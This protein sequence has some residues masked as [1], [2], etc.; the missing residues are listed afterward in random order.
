MQDLLK[1][2]EG[3]GVKSYGEV[4]QFLN[5]ATYSR[6][7]LETDGPIAYVHYGDI[8]VKWN[9]VLN[10]EQSTLPAINQSQ[11]RSY[12]L[13]K[14]GDLVMADASEDYSGIGKS[15]EVK[16]LKERLAIS[17]LHTILLRDY[18]GI[19]INGFRGYLHEIRFIKKQF[20][21]LATGMKVYGVSKN[22]LKGVLISIPPIDEQKRITSI[23]SEMDSEI[24]AL[25]QK[26]AKCK[27]M[28]QGMMQELLTGRIRLV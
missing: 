17:G 4:F 22:K 11:A 1:P 5:T 23:L 18:Q 16:N 7:D 6:A 15:V 24:S 12:S 10:F 27:M 2:K 25:E 28:K 8:H 21:E 9:N 26:L 20:D 14:E 3:W 13:L 19:F